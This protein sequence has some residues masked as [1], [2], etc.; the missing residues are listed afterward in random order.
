MCC[1]TVETVRPYIHTQQ[2]GNCNDYIEMYEIFNPEILG[3]EP[4]NPGILGLRNMSG[5]YVRLY[6]N[7][8][9]EIHAFNDGSTARCVNAT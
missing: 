1:H 9:I 8:S 3:L 5:M 2:R 4:P 7:A 6:F